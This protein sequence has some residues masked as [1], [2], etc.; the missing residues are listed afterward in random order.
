MYK[1]WGAVALSMI[2]PGAGRLYLGEY[3]NGVLTLIGFSG[4]LSAFYLI[5]SIYPDFRY[6]IG[7]GAIFYYIGNIYL[8]LKARN[9]LNL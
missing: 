2:A 7:A 6:Y 8:T 3:W 5:E 4:L 1:K 9:I